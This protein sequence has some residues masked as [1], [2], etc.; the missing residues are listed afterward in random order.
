[1]NYQQYIVDT[2][3]KAATEFF[4]N[5]HAVPADKVE[6]SP[7]DEGRSVLDLCREI[8]MTPVWGI[9]ILGT[10]Q[11]EW[12]EEVAAKT[13][14]EQAEWLTVADCE[15]IWNER[16]VALEQAYLNIPDEKLAETKWLP[17]DGGRDFTFI[18]MLDYPRWNLNYHAGQ[19]C[20]IQTLL[21]DKEM[22]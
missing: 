14:A 16:F 18:E 20:Y 22:H 7:L 3:R 2:T 21:G 5:A 4:R 11:M 9:S 1:M 17:Y 8:G 19:I 6:W 13:K 10:E 12:N 15:A